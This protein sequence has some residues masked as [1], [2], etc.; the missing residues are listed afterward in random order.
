MDLLEKS[1]SHALNLND[2]EELFIET[3]GISPMEKH[4]LRGSFGSP[5]IYVDPVVSYLIGAT[6]GNAYKNQI[7]KLKEYPIPNLRMSDSPGELFLDI[8]C[9]WGRWSISAARKGYKVIGIDPSIGAVMA[10]KRV[11]A[12]LNLDIDYV[13]GDARFLPFSQDSFDVAF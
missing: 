7:G 1:L 12:K 6:N 4:D 10:A 13:V 5:S 3:L 2:E 9:S 11:A 8:G